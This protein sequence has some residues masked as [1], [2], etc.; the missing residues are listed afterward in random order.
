M[1]VHMPLQQY[2]EIGVEVD[3]GVGVG[4]GVVVGVGLGDGDGVGEGVGDDVIIIL[5]SLSD[6]PNMGDSSTVV[7][8]EIL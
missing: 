6:C 2:H 4:L 3:V 1:V 8:T 5:K 7:F